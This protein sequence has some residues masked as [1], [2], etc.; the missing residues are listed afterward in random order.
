MSSNRKKRTQKPIEEQERQ[1]YVSAVT[2]TQVWFDKATELLLLAEIVEQKLRESWTDARKNTERDVIL[3]TEDIVKRIEEER[4]SDRWPLQAQSLYLMLVAFAIE[5]LCKADIVRTQ[6]LVISEEI[7]KSGKLSEKLK[8]HD[9]VSLVRKVGLNLDQQEQTLL[10]NLQKTA[11]W[12]ARYPVPVEAYRKILP[13]EY[14]TVVYMKATSPEEY[15]DHV[16]ALV[17]KLCEKIRTNGT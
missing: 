16:K 7:Q 3:K 15:M 5:N 4:R 6:G 12:T 8:T 1:W 9:L 2:N 17:S 11:V 14:A 10:R 13:E